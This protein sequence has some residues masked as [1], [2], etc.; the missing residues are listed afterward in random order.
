[1]PREMLQAIYNIV[2]GC[3][4]QYCCGV[5]LYTMAII[6]YSMRV[7]YTR[8]VQA[9][10]HVKEEV[11]GL[12][13]TEKTYADSIFARPGRQAEEDVQEHDIKAPMHRMENGRKI[14]LA[15]L[16][17][18]ILS[19]P[20]RK[21]RYKEEHQKARERQYHFWPVSNASSHNVKMKVVGFK[22]GGGRNGIGS[23]YCF[24]ADPL[25]GIRL[26]ARRFFCSCDCCMRKL[27]LGTIQ[28]RYDGPF[29]QC[30][31]WPLFKIDDGNG[32]KYVLV[33]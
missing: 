30:K 23:H 2:D 1:M 7:R 21:F 6:S 24:M 25:L 9:P 10:G 32:W 28:D 13:G 27:S 14:S 11:D 22:R 33:C 3:A 26:A 16:M 15:K 31:Y 4:I 20:K 12:I 8:C 29:D 19:N 17:Y 18:D 5:V